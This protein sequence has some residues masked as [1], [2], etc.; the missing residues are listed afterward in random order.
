[1]D[2]NDGDELF[3]LFQQ[4][5]R[6]KEEIRS[7]ESSLETEIGRRIL[8]PIYKILTEEGGEYFQDHSKYIHIRELHMD[9]FLVWF[10]YITEMG[11]AKLQ[12]I[13]TLLKSSG[14]RLEDIRDN[15]KEQ[16]LMLCIKLKGDE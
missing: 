6:L 9:G 2:K 10:E 14:F 1:M 11:F 12:E 15:G 7:T 16:G 4:R 13:D 3:K 5:N 8:W